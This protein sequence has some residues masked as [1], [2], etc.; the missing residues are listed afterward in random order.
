M[1]LPYSQ[2]ARD[3]NIVALELTLKD[4]QYF[5][6][7]LRSILLFERPLEGV[8]IILGT[9]FLLW[10][11]VSQLNYASWVALSL[12]IYL[13]GVWVVDAVSVS[14]PWERWLQRHTTALSQN[15]AKS[16]TYTEL[17]QEISC[18]TQIVNNIWMAIIAVRNLNKEKFTV[19]TTFI[20]LMVAYVGTFASGFGLLYIT[21]YAFLLLPALC[22]Y[23]IPFQIKEFVVPFIAAAYDL[24]SDPSTTTTPDSDSDSDDPAHAHTRVPDL[25]VTPVAFPLGAGGGHT[26]GGGILGDSAELSSDDEYDVSISEI[27]LEDFSSS[28]NENDEFE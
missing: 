6:L 28:E 9:H 16:L 10:Y 19:Y 24:I 14:I 27:S 12:A 23:H 17:I 26:G 7:Y 25:V 3:K 18:V 8:T 15:H 1:Q 5:L 4:Y 2:R 11:V 21:V 22:V 13:V 20:L